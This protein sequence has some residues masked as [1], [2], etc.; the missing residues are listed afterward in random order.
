MPHCVLEGTQ[1]Q[2]IVCL[3]DWRSAT[4]SRLDCPWRATLL[5][6]YLFCYEYQFSRILRPVRALIE[7]GVNAFDLKP[8]TRQQVFGFKAIQVTHWKRVHQAF[9]AAIGVRD[10]VNEFNLVNLVQIV[11]GEN[12]VPPHHAAAVGTRKLGL[13]AK[14][15][16]QIVLDERRKRGVKQVE[17]QP[18][19]FS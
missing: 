4:G 11:P 7:I 6:V 10:V 2:D 18:A 1:W 17:D 16:T 13:V 19:A 9:L 14:L 3:T 8:T 5:S 12:L 15:L